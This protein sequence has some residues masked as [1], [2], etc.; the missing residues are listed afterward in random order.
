M[1]DPV[2]DDTTW[3]GTRPT[4]VVAFRAMADGT[5]ADY[6]LLDRYERMYAAGL[7][8]RILRSLGHLEGSLGGYRITRLE[9]SLQAATRARLDGAD[10][11]WI[12][13]SAPAGTR[14][15]STPISPSHP[16]A[17][18]E[19]EVRAVFTRSAWAVDVVSPGA[20]QLPPPA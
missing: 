19:P 2:K 7:P 17:S 14:R 18:F 5:A 15:A 1:S 11:D 16:L 13:T 6:A 3:D 10:A 9:H 8:D 4:G 12:V 20:Q